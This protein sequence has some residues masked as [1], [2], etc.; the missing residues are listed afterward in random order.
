MLIDRILLVHI[1]T[2][3][4]IDSLVILPNYNYLKSSFAELSN[5][6]FSS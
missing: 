2:H 3:F 6:T 4:L 1:S 5:L